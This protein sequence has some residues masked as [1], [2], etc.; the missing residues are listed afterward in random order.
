MTINFPM[1][2]FQLSDLGQKANTSAGT[3]SGI[4]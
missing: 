4:T 1:L 2:Q 3:S